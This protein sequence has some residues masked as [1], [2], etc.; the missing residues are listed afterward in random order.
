ML[1][2]PHTWQ[3]WTIAIG[4]LLFFF[5][6]LPS[7]FGA[8]KPSWITSGTTGLILTVFA[9]TFWTLDLVYGALTAALVALGW[10]ILCIQKIRE[11]IIK[12]PHTPRSQSASDH[13]Q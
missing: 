10:Y 13:H 11:Q 3:D 4:Q 12:P 6:L 9:Y 7:I 1:E 2:L 8:H 5:A